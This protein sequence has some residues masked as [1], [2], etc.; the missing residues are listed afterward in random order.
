MAP[1]VLITGAT[2]FIGGSVLERLT[3]EHPEYNYTA[4]LRNISDE[5]TSTYPNVK[6]VK[7]D[8]DST[9]IITEAASQAD[10]VVH[11]GNSDHEA[12]IRALTA[13]LLQHSDA[14]GKPSYLIHLGGTGI[15]AD[16][17]DPEPNYHG[18][19]NPKVWS[20]VDDIDAIWSL[21][22]GALH[23]NVD[24]IIQETWTQHGDKLKT[25]IMCP[26]DIY[27]RG[28]GPGRKL[29]VFTPLFVQE[30]KE[31]GATFYVNEGANTRS[32]VHVDDLTTVYLKLVEAAVTGDKNAGW[33]RE[34]YYF[35]ASQEHAH[36]DVASHV[37]KLMAAQGVIPSPEPKK[38]SLDE[39]K[40]MAGRPE[41]AIYQFAAN[42]RTRSHR[43]QQLLGYR[44][45]APGLL[46]ALEGDV[47]SAEDELHLSHSGIVAGAKY[48]A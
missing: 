39:V 40:K 38:L 23:R 35:A 8:Y 22:D 34:G 20:D 28:R 36:I 3:R 19:L 45:I 18:K 4:L 10:V 43:A 13:G 17:Q 25:A 31:T 44:P 27:G 32:W 6:T 1:N 12:S 29:S 21:P 5:F 33:G 46:E 11:N 48:K 15:V 24:K 47:A 7:G 2:G 26:P 9:D 30:V 37:G 41:M 16:F 14:T 42:S